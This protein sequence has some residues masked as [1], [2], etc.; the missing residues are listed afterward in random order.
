MKMELK[1]FVI[2]LSI[3]CIA[4]LYF[5]ST[6]TQPILIDLYELSEYDGK[7]VIVKGVVME[8]HT[9]SYGGHIIEI[10]DIKNSKNSTEAI[11][12]VEE[13][14]SVEYRDRIQVTGKVQKYKDEWEVVVNNKRFVKILQKWDNITFPVWQ[15]AE[16]PVKYLGMNVNV[17]GLIDRIYDSYFYLIDSEEQYSIVVYYDTSKFYNFSQ[18]DVV[19]VG[20]RFVYDKETLR[21]V[22]DVNEETHNIYVK[23]R[24]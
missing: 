3:V 1:Y 10:K 8:H 16:N 15:L 7:Q 19:Y 17:T 4:F 13:A 20:A 24:E 18:G 22:L 6:L 14:T 12:F 5:L 9:T 11:V 21:Y 23:E 2:I